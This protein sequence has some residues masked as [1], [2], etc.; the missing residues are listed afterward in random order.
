MEDP[1]ST[2]SLNEER[3]R[4]HLDSNP[5]FLFLYFIVFFFSFFLS[6]SCYETKTSWKCMKEIDRKSLC[7]P[8][9]FGFSCSLE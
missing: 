4:P 2:R 6:F 7:K 9:S 3:V 8:T 1:L 5:F